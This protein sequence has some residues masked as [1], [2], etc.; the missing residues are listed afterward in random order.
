MKMAGYMIMFIIAT[1]DHIQMR[2]CF[3]FFNNAY[4]KTIFV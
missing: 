4:R 2:N 1:V 3:H